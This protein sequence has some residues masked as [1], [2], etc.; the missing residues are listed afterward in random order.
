MASSISLLVLDL[1]DER[2]HVREQ[3][4]GEL[5]G[6]LDVLLGVLRGTNTGRGAGQDNRAGEQGGTLR[7]E[8]DQLRDSE[9]QVTVA[10]M[11]LAFVSM[12]IH[13]VER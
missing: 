4:D 9:D 5:V 10:Q 8:A 1:V 6:P 12:E 13:I 11:S 3:L 2:A 7:E